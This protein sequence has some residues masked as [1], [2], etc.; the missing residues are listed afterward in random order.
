MEQIVSYTRNTN[1][2][3]CPGN[4][5]LP[6]NRQSPFN[7]FNGAR[8]AYVLVNDD[9]SVNSKEIRF[10]AEDVLSGDTIDNGQ[11]FQPNDCDKDDLLAELCW[12]SSERNPGSGLA[13]TPQGS[14]HSLCRWSREVVWRL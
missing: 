5:Q 8:A 4:M 7:Y 12:R 14:E 10:P 1:V 3:H 13:G 11:Y 6:M 9:A 2:Y